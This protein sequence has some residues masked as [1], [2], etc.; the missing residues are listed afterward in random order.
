MDRAPTGSRIWGF[1]FLAALTITF[2]TLALTL[3]G[4]GNRRT[5]D[6]STAPKLTFHGAFSWRVTTVPSRVRPGRPMRF[7]V[8]VVAPYGPLAD[9][10][11]AMV[12]FGDGSGAASAG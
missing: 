9:Y 5:T 6:A 10:D 11:M 1:G 3:P 2:G 8:S 12:D 7:S 4:S